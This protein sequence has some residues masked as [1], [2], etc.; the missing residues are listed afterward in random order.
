MA[1]DT[2]DTKTRTNFNNWVV[3]YKTVADVL[4][5]LDELAKGKVIEDQKQVADLQRA[6]DTLLIDKGYRGSGKVREEASDLLTFLTKLDPDSL[7]EE[8]EEDDKMEARIPDNLEELVEAYEEAKRKRDGDR[9][10]ILER[11]IKEET[12]MGVSEFIKRQKEMANEESATGDEAIELED[13]P[14]RKEDEGGETEVRN[15]VPKT[16]VGVK[17]ILLTAGVEEKVAEK[18]VKKTVKA[19]VVDIERLKKMVKKVE[20]VA[21]AEAVLEEVSGAILLEEARVVAEDLGEELST[22]EIEIDEEILVDK[23]MNCWRKNENLEMGGGIREIIEVEGGREASEDQKTV[24]EVAMRRADQQIKRVVETKGKVVETE[25]LRVIK[26]EIVESV[27]KAGEIGSEEMKIVEKYADFVVNVYKDNPVSGHKIRVVTGNPLRTGAIEKGFRRTEVLTSL[28]SK[29]EVRKE[30]EQFAQYRDLIKNFGAT[31]SVDASRSV[32][33]MFSFLQHSPEM[34]NQIENIRNKIAWAQNWGDK[35][36]GIFKPGGID[37]L[38]LD[39]SQKM[40]NQPLFQFVNE[41]SILMSGGKSFGEALGITLK[42][43]IANG[44]VVAG[45]AVKEGAVAAGETAAVG[46]VAAGGGALASLL[47]G[48]LAPVVA[49][50]IALAPVIKKGVEKISGFFEKMGLSLGIK[51]WAKENFGKVGGWLAGA[52][53]GMGGMFLGVGGILTASLAGIGGAIGMVVAG[54][55]IAIAVIM[56]FFAGPMVGSLVPP[57]EMGAGTGASYDTK[58]PVLLAQKINQ[59]ANGKTSASVKE[60]VNMEIKQ[61]KGD[62]ANIILPRGGC[63]FSQK[64]C[65]PTAV[66]KVL[67]NKDAKLTPDYLVYDITGSAY[68]QMGC[69]G[70]SL[71][72]AQQT[73]IKYL[74]INSID[75]TY[76]STTRRCNKQDIANWICEDKIVMVLTNFYSSSDLKTTGH[77]VLA[78]EYKEGEIYTADPYFPD[79]ATMDGQAKY[80]H[81]QAIR[82]C[83]VI[84]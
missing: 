5:S 75:T 83:L 65:G 15:E 54:P 32:N 33:E 24:I 52:M 38:F 84:N 44:K 18:I 8:T 78:V 51:K 72:Q 37:N 39:V 76:D 47:S 35:I 2:T 61:N 55:I 23:V 1:T 53:M 20:S 71:A 7:I 12:G 77:H 22:H 70:S 27:I 9:C 31:D 10:R 41:T 64:A 29:G 60:R 14:D 69:E 6:V 66:S 58:A 68:S 56:L 21:A 28:I 4:F 46:G 82:D 25:R 13:E 17:E 57:V 36:I 49:A 62:W 19:E 80:G 40:V 34:V 74:G 73:F 16:K 30:I 81:V 67:I 50:V 63:N 42:S 43:L 26:K 79:G 11:A 45:T 59:C 48:P 3:T